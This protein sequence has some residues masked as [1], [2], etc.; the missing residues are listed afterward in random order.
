MLL[1]LFSFLYFVRGGG[2]GR[3]TGWE[4]TG[5]FVLPCHCVHLYKR[6]ACTIDLV[7][8]FHVMSV[9]PRVPW[10]HMTDYY[11]QSNKPGNRSMC[12][13]G[14]NKCCRSVTA[15]L[16]TIQKF[17]L[18]TL[19]QRFKQS[20]SSNCSHRQANMLVNHSTKKYSIIQY[21]VSIRHRWICIPSERNN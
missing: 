13:L 5:H 15:A 1:S 12:I 10:G 21:T 17:Y 2:G 18:C 9:W 14:L 3:G 4:T 11:F 20:H 16:Y 8:A 6:A 19:P 7:F